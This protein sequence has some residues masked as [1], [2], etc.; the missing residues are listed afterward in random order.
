MRSRLTAL[1]TGAS[2]GIGLELAIVLARH[3]HDVV[4][5][6]RSERKL[7]TLAEELHATYGARATVIAAD[8]ADRDGAARVTDALAERAITIDVL[9]N[10][11]GVGLSGAFA[12]H[13]LSDELALL[14]LDIVSL[15]E[16]TR[17]LLPAMLHV[18]RGR[19]LNVASTAAFLPGPFMATYYA[20][21]A[22]VLSFSQALASELRGTGVTVT[23]LCPGPTRTGFA[24]A[25]RMQQTKLARSANVMRAD[26]VARAGYEG[27]VRGVPVV[28]PGIANKLLIES[29][30]L[31]P[32][33]LLTAVTRRLNTP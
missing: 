12:E 24:D 19:V 29:M 27:L 9:V 20:S 21:K 10:N 4:L 7:A 5:V 2:G 23:A 22:F 25:A 11:A 1:V 31:A 14:Q 17:R 6:A 8:L 33:R 16:L 3:E 28:I 26:D 18:R 13:A 15:V 32:R 30:R